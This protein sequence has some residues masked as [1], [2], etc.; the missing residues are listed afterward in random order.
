MMQ[1]KKQ[2]KIITGKKK[3]VTFA[4]MVQS[5]NAFFILQSVF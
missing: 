5:V 2:A 1:N 3:L 4:L